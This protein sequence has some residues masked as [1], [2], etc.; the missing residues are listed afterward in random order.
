MSNSGGTDLVADKIWQIDYYDGVIRGIAKAQDH[1]YLF[2]LV[3]WDPDSRRRAYVILNLDHTTA[4]EMI[5]LCELKPEAESDDE[6]RWRRVDQI[7]DH[8]I[9]H[10]Q[11]AAY[12]SNEEPKV[13]ETVAMT[14]IPI[15]HITE[16][17]GF[18]IENT[19][20]SRA[21]ELWFTMQTD[22]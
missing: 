12:L 19:M 17:R 9:M 7:Y 2:T 6:E 10:Y 5:R 1:Y 22:D 16:L 11:N 3:A 21:Q 13:T 8:Y 15:D 18:D 20:D 4:D 14:S